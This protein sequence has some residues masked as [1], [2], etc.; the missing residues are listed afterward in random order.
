V[1]GQTYPEYHSHLR[2]L[3][4]KLGKELQGPM[5]GFGQLH[6]AVLTDGALSV[7]IKELVALAV[8]V[9]ARCQGCIAFHT[10]DALK[11]GA[12]RPEVLEA[13]GVAVLMGGGPS[14]MYACEALEALEQFQAASSAKP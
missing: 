4:G 2:N 3:L 9:S 12:S 13:L 5:A 8:A 14:V 6:K 11:A 7:K 1:T 10:H